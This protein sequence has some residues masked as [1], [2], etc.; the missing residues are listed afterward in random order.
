M[1]KD[2]LS[3]QWKRE[4]AID[5]EC[6]DED[7]AVGLDW[8]GSSSWL[9]KVKGKSQRHLLPLMPVIMSSSGT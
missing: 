4:G 6:G 3:L 8:I 2:V 9:L 7:D 5:G 1:K